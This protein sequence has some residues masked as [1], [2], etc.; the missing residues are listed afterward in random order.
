MTL[1]WQFFFNSQNSTNQKILKTD[2]LENKF[3]S[4]SKHIKKMTR[5]CVVEKLFATSIN[6]LYSEYINDFYKLIRQ[7]SKKSG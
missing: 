3:I 7:F 6:K 2:N 5:Q 4:S 1:E